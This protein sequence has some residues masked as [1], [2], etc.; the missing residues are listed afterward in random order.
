M[1]DISFEEI[2]KEEKTLL[3]K[4]FDFDVDEKGVIIDRLFNEKLVSK[5]TNKEITIDNASLLPGSLEVIG[6]TPLA[7]SSFIRKKMELKDDGS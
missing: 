5:E 7:L 3:L 4:A 1:S 6:T 2:G